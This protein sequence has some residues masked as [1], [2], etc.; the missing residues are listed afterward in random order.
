MAGGERGRDDLRWLDRIIGIPA[1]AVLAVIRKKKRIPDN[2]ST[3]GLIALGAIGDTILSVGPAMPVLRKAFPKARLALFTSESNAHVASLLPACDEL[4]VIPVKD[5]IR[6]ISLLR[7]RQQDV[8]IDFGPWPRISAVFAALSKA[9]Y[10]VGFK[11]PRQYRHYVYDL[12][13]DHSDEIHEFENYANLLSALGVER[14]T[15]PTITPSDD[16]TH[17]VRREHPG[18]YIVC[19]PWA[20]GFKREMREW[21][22][23]HWQELAGRLIQL[24]YKVVFTG[25]PS[26]EDK[27]DTLIDGITPASLSI[28][29]TAGRYD[30]DE[31]AALLESS[32]CVVSVNTGVMHLAAAMKLPL[33]ALHGPTNPVRWGPLSDSAKSILPDAKNTAFLHLG[34][35]YPKGIEPFMHLIRVDEVFDAVFEFLAAHKTKK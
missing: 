22:N 18:Q 20:S 29:H 4:H 16:A 7:S 13:V 24:G 8:L 19:H 3:I 14:P 30:I 11:T 35:E 1:V 33:V 9:R 27:S 2:V 12:T 10:I 17:R 5:P 15:W 6:S 25:S 21:P 34:F 26:D 32:Q 23:K 28:S 31:T